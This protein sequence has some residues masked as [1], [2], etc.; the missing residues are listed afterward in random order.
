[1]QPTSTSNVHVLERH[2]ARPLLRVPK[3]DTGGAYYQ[4]YCDRHR[5][6]S[7]TTA[8]MQSH[9]AALGIT[10]VAQQTGLD[11]IGIP[12]YAAFRP[13]AR[14][15][16]VNQGKGLDDDSAM[17][18]AIME[19]AEFAIAEQPDLEV[20]EATKGTFRTKDTPVFDIHRMMPMGQTIPDD[21][22]ISWVEGAHLFSGHTIM[23]PYDAILLDATTASA[24]NIT[25][26]TNGLASGNTEQEA[27]FHSLCELIERDSSS[28]FS[29]RTM[30]QCD[31]ACID[32]AR[33]ND[34]AIDHLCTLIDAADLRLTLFNQTSDL[35]VPVIMAVIA[36]TQQKIAQHFDVTA[37]YGCHPV[38]A[39]AAIRAITE[40]AQSRITNIA[41]SRDDFDPTE[42]K[43]ELASDL[44]KF[45]RDDLPPLA[46][47]PEGCAPDTSL[48]V[49]LSFVRARLR[50]NQIED[51]VLVR[52]GGAAYG[53][54]VVRVLAPQLEDRACN[55]HWRPGTR[56]ASQLMETT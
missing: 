8:H 10:R 38:P 26:T 3:F 14:T 34:D 32:P 47:V 35:G 2:L 12:T 49:L 37:G 5:P 30:E 36:E 17:A 4:H 29:L 7:E 9:L 13:N 50:E 44:I 45:T 15:L 53:I 42:Y 19:A 24:H 31:A 52:L 22:E 40:A 51:V 25:R 48:D 43:M 20:I 18:S 27:I 1:M 21:A 23:V 28:L 33:F 39:R 6:P 54:S 46:E 16:A 41:G 55:P 56:A 11:R